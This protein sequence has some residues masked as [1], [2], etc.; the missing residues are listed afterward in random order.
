MGRND[1]S[2]DEIEL[3]EKHNWVRDR[4]LHPDIIKKGYSHLKKNSVEDVV[5]V[6]KLY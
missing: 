4:K 5:G 2:L 3:D 1:Y 6:E